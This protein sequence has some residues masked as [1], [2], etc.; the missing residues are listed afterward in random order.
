MHRHLR[1]CAVLLLSVA[2]S[3]NAFAAATQGSK[4][5]AVQNARYAAIEACSRQAQA[6]AMV[7]VYGQ[8]E[9]GKARTLVYKSCMAQRGFVP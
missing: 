8:D 9:V 3:A 2:C 5:N 4:R 6:W 1:S 7:S